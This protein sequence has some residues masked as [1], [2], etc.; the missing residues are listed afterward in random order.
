MNGNEPSKKNLTR[1]LVISTVAR[2][3]RN[4]AYGA[5]AVVFAI[6]LG[7]RGL[8]PSLVG[9]TLSVA[10]VSGALSSLSTAWL[11]RRVGRTATLVGAALL[12]AV[13]GAM[14]VFARHPELLVL[15]A[16]LGTLSPGGQ[17]VGPFAA[18]EQT[19]IARGG[20]EKR[21]TR[22]FVLYNFAGTLA[23]ALGAA[24]AGFLGSTSTLW[25]YAAAGLALA[26][27]YPLLPAH[28]PMRAQGPLAAPRRWTYVETLTLLFGVDALAGGFVVQSFIAYW[29]HVRFGASIAEL[30]WLFFGANVLSA[31]SF[32]AAI[33][34]AERFGNL[35]TMVFTHLPSNVLLLLVPLMPTFG[36]AA[37]VLLARYALSQMDVPT[38]QAFMMEIVSD[39]ERPRMAGMAT[40]VRPAAAAVAPL[41]SGIALQSSIV[42]LP[43]FVAG[44]LKIVYD[45]AILA[46]FGRTRPHA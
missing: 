28:A 24:S 4:F 6:A 30:G 15:A 5:F 17:E 44:G 39:D 32:A 8:S 16:T 29:L 22:R 10:L 37:I 41:L 33:P 19:A 36:G 13:S 20:S 45:L 1:A 23:G 27:L 38:R 2:S 12:M 7:E 40:A 43:F 46:R 42:A 26:A 18:L 34:L 14:L 3:L 31:L 11:E 21:A 9:A 25:V 35:R